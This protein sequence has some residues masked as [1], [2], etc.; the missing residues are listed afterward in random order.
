MKPDLHREVEIWSEEQV[1]EFLDSIEDHR[2]AVGF[3]LGVLF[4]LRRSE[5]LALRWNDLDERNQTVTIDE[6]FVSVRTG[7][8]WTDAKNA[9]SR[10]VVPLDEETVQSFARRRQLQAAEKLLAGSRWQ[11]SDTVL[12]TTHG[13][14]VL[15]TSFDR[16][17][18]LVTEKA[19]LPRLSSHGLRHTAATH[20]VRHAEDAGQL[21]AAADILGHSPDMLMRTYAHTL[22]ESLRAITAK[23]AQRSQR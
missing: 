22:P 3:R 16:A 1:V 5:I 23:I 4:G 2:W 10:R 19:D 14:P 20:M 8:S 18:R 11:G 7:A 21:R 12:T 17:L 6:G 9:R 15:P 13:A